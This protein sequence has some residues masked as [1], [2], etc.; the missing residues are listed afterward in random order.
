[1]IFSVVFF[2]CV[3]YAS[4]VLA[5]TAGGYYDKPCNLDRVELLNLGNFSCGY[6][7]PNIDNRME[8]P[9]VQF[10]KAEEGELYTLLLVNPDFRDS[11]CPWKTYALYWLVVD[12]DGNDFKNGVNASNYEEIVPYTAPDAVFGIHRFHTFA[13]KQQKPLEYNGPD[14]DVLRN[15]ERFQLLQFVEDN[16][17]ELKAGFEFLVDSNFRNACPSTAAT[18]PTPFPTTSSSTLPPSTSTTTEE[19]TTE[20]EIPTELP[21]EGPIELPTEIPTTKRTKSMKTTKVRGPVTEPGL[22]AVNETSKVSSLSLSYF[23]LM[24]LLNK[25]I[26]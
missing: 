5:D 13:F 21:T 14:L 17:L 3:Y 16:D 9:N 20:Y 19:E 15:R 6:E 22:R 2:L 7:Q 4:V 11:N 23:S 12:I 8:Q 1:M 24:L 10:S 26:Q 25:A 18:V